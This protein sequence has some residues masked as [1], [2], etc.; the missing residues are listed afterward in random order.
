[1]K[2]LRLAVFFLALLLLTGCNRLPVLRRLPDYVS[3]GL[4]ACYALQDSTEYGKYC[5]GE[6]TAQ[7]LRFFGYF[8]PVTEADLET[9]RL[10]VQDFE[11]W[12]ALCACENC[13]CDLAECYDFSAAFLEAGDYFG[14]ERREPRGSFLGDYTIYYFDMET[15]TLY[16]LRCNI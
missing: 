5:F 4:H 3:G 16:Y 12:V 6:V 14:L 10:Y 1:M 11:Q 13:D 7:Q 8:R 15:Q 9:L 2:K